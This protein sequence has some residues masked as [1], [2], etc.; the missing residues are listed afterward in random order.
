VS[1]RA[2]DNLEQLRL[3]PVQVFEE[4]DRRLLRYELLKEPSP[5]LLQ[6]PRNCKWMKV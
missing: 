6:C 3:R 2:V 5:G 4:N 1:K